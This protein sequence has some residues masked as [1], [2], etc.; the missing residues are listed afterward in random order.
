MIAANRCDARVWLA[1]TP[2]VEV[3]REQLSRLLS[4]LSEDLDRKSVV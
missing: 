4:G 3:T 2:T 1:T